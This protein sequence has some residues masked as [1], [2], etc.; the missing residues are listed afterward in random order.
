MRNTYV[1]LSVL[2]PC[3]YKMTVAKNPLAAILDTNRLTGPNYV[4]WLRNLKL[5]LASEDLLYVL[6][7]EI[8][9]E[10]AE[11]APEAEKTAFQKWKKDETKA[12]VTSW[13]LCP[14][15]YRGSMRRWSLLGISFFI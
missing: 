5:V 13:S 15:H 14:I 10:P 11:D 3:R 12:D 1:K 6:D 2:C 8:P 4:D 9:A 7:G